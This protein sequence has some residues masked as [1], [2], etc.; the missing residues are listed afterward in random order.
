MITQF[1][2]NALDRGLAA[3]VGAIP[4]P[5]PDVLADLTA[6][7]SSGGPIMAAA[8][9][10]GPIVP[11]AQFGHAL[12]LVLACVVAG[13]VIQLVKIGIS[14]VTGGGGAT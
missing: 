1:I 7:V 4:A 11:F 13:W 9:K 14:Y 2:L 3:L 8:T 5:A 10:F 12:R 6:A